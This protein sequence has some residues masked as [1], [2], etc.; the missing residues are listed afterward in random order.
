MGIMTQHLQTQPC[1]D[2]LIFILVL[3]LNVKLKHKDKSS[4]VALILTAFWCKI[5]ITAYLLL[6]GYCVVR[7]GPERAEG[8]GRERVEEGA[9]PQ[10]QTQKTEM[11][12]QLMGLR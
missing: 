10:I 12:L 5:D 4:K 6:C 11:G 7:I 1:L 9:W 3:G 8:C 2:S